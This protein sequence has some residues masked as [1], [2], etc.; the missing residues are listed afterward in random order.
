MAEARSKRIEFIDYVPKISP[1]DLLAGAKTQTLPRKSED[2]SLSNKRFRNMANALGIKRVSLLPQPKG[3]N[4]CFQRL[5]G[6]IGAGPTIANLVLIPVGFAS[7]NFGCF[8]LLRHDRQT[9]H[10]TPV[11][12]RSSG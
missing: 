2:Q 1:T 5:S 7:G 10:Q 8:G 4:L 9:N 11:V 3:D 6:E 12:R